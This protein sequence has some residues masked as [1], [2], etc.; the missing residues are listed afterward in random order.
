MNVWTFLNFKGGVA[1][2]ASTVN[3]SAVLAQKGYKVLVID[4]DKQS[5]STQYLNGYDEECNSMYHVFTGQN[6]LSEIIYKTE[7]DNIYIARAT[8]QLIELD[9]ANL[10]NDYNILKGEVNKLEG[11]D[12]V[13]I[14]CPAI[15]N[16]VVFNA[17]AASNNVFI[18]ISADNWALNGFSYLIDKIE[19]IKQNYNP[20]TKFAGTFM[21]I[22]TPHYNLSKEF[23]AELSEI[24]GDKLLKQSIRRNVTLPRSTFHAKPVVYFDKNANSAVDYFSLTEEIL[25]I[26]GGN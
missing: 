19:E 15:Y 25:Q 2:T 5:N 22:D 24:L 11:F 7:F 8:M 3:I 17:I 18:P 4:C 13:L 10:D 20:N 26:T 1:K 21:T 12:Y 16:M 23:R 14:D 6:E 9:T